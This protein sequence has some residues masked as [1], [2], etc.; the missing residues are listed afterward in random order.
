MILESEY[1]NQIITYSYKF[2]FDSGRVVS[3][4]VRLNYSDLSLADPP[5]E[6]P[7]FWTALDYRQCPNCT[8]NIDRNP[9]CPVARSLSHIIEFFKDSVSYHQ[10]ELTIVTEERNF[11]RLTT[12]QQGIS[13]LLGI[14]M[15]SSGCP[16]L[17]KLKPMVRFHLPFATPEE[18]TYRAASMY[19]LAQY[20]KCTRGKKPDWDLTGLIK[21]YDRV[22][23]VN[24]AFA[25]R[26]MGI[27]NKDASLN[28]VVI[29]DNFGNFI[30]L[31]INHEMLSDMLKYFAPL[32]EDDPDDPQQ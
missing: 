30:K 16:I 28:A 9:Y 20:L 11:S 26:L 8:L 24:I 18:T 7:P 21:I 1:P 15:V 2:R 23:Q 17:E 14:Y 32:M 4:P 25:K 22:Q 13:S 10:V 31:S 29:L 12:L 3:F 6:N 5:P 19:L 27:Q